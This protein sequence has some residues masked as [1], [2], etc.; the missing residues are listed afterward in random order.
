[1]WYKLELRG[2]K[3]IALTVGVDDDVEH[4]FSNLSKN[5]LRFKSI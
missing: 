3:N 4:H 5:I 2:R 1:M